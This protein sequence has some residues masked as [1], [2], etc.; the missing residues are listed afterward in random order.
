MIDFEIPDEVNMVRDTVARFVED[1]LLPL[2]R[3]V[4]FIEEDIPLDTM[5]E[6]R[7]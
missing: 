6:L 4:G 5:R 2:E 3:E 1:K 7:T